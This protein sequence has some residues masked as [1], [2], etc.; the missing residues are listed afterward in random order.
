MKNLVINIDDRFNLVRR[1]GEGGFGAVYEGRDIV[2]NEK[3]AIKLEHIRHGYDKLKGEADAYKAV[4]GGRGI[5]RAL[6]FGQECDYYVLVLDL[7]GPSL[8]DL[9]DYC[10]RRFSLKTV[11]LLA[12]QLITRL[13]YIHSKSLVYRD[14]KPDN[15]LMGTG[16]QGNVV[17]AVDFGLAEDYST[18]DRRGRQEGTL[19]YASINFHKE[20]ELH[21]GD[22]LES[23][24]YVLVYFLQGSLPWQD[25]KVA[26]GESKSARIGELK[27]KLSAKDLCKC[28]PVEFATFLDYTRTLLPGRK[29]KYAWLRGLFH[30]LVKRHKLS[31]DNVFDWTIRRYFEMQA[32]D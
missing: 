14:V 29:P 24:G 10:D 32:R 21:P 6:W 19:R 30:G 4:G 26:K 28:L 5:P 16:R 23:L 31:Y 11:L 18:N 8:E 13:E 22:D 3:V 25:V 17:H 27:T 1:I 12:D 2:T 7:L 9:F 15:F 20:L